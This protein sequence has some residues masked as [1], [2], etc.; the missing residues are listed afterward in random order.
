M[1]LLHWRKFV[2]FD[3]EYVSGTELNQLVSLEEPRDVLDKGQP[4]VTV[5][6]SCSSSGRG[7]ILLG[8]TT[9]YVYIINKHLKVNSFKANQKS[10]SHLKQVPKL[11]LFI[12]CGSDQEGINPLIKLWDPEKTDRLNQPTCIRLIRANSGFTKPSPVTCIECNDLITLM[13]VGYEDGSIVLFHGDIT[14]QRRTKVGRPNKV[15]DHPITGIVIRNEAKVSASLQ[16][17]SDYLNPGISLIETTAFVASDQEIFYV[18]LSEKTFSKIQLD[19]QG[20]KPR[21]SC[22]LSGTEKDFCDNL[23]AVGR[24]NAVYFYQVD[25]RGPCLAFDGEKLVLY[26]FKSYLVILSRDS[27]NKADSNLLRNRRT[28]VAEKENIDLLQNAKRINLN[29]YD[30]NHKYIAHSSVI[31]EIQEIFSEWGQLFVICTNGQV[32]TFREKDTQ[33]KL[34]ILF[35]KNQFSLVI[36]IAKSHQYNEDALTDIFKHY[37]DHL[38]RKGDYDGAILQYIKTIG[39]SEPSYVIKKFLD[40]RRI[41]NLTV[42]LEALH[43]KSNASQDHTKLLLN[44]YS[45]LRNDQQ[46][47]QFIESYEEGNIK[48]DVEIAIEV[49]RDAGFYEFAI[50]LARKHRKHASYFK[51]QIED[52]N[53]I[54]AA[55]NYMEEMT[56]PSEMAL[57]MRKYGRIM[58]REA[59]EKTV[60]MIKLICQ[61]SR[62]HSDQGQSDG[63]QLYVANISRQIHPEEFFHIFVDNSDLFISLLE[64]LVENEVDFDTRDV[65][66]LLLELYLKGWC[67]ERDDLMRNLQ[68]DKIKRLLSKSSDKLDLEKAFILCRNNRFDEGL[69]DL[70]TRTGLHH[71]VLQYYIDQDD[72]LKIMKTCEQYGGENLDLYTSA[73]IHYA[74]TGDDRLSQILKAVEHHKLMPPMVVIKILLESKRACLGSVKEYLVRFLSKLHDRHL[75]N[76]NAVDHYKDDTEVVRQRIEEFENH[77]T[78]FKPSKCS[79]CQG[80]LD[81]PS[82]HFLCSHSYHQNCFHNYSAESDECPICVTTNKKL[83]DEIGSHENSK[84]TLDKLERQFSSPSDDIFNSLAKL[85]GYGLFN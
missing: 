28:Q 71:L 43:K 78:V 25:G 70:Y 39:K 62:G 10:T 69:I 3:E 67:R 76:Q 46:L 45:K 65:H 38:Y 77:Q 81:L 17:N 44:C 74:R 66:N 2:F 19:Q 84:S 30:I 57:Y 54:E 31:P 64:R 6:L 37:G 26:R 60:S 22:L 53:D 16:S 63:R 75:D 15:S 9:G 4:F 32:V 55:L 82:V 49:L 13:A 58:L 61:R 40:S 11:P 14:K 34:E 79:A 41:S 68:A 1:A 33:T 56:D 59:P 5:K 85:F 83:L 23:F 24:N 18:T 12:T 36:D 29:I 51:F 42:Y 50:Y 80:A 20:C 52:T 27:P 47:K 72:S 21:C 8:D 73:L 35:R 48:F 7:S